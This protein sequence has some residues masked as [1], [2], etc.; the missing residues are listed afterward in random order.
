ML[1]LEMVLEVVLQAAME[2]V[3]EAVMEAE[4]VMAQAPLLRLPEM[5]SSELHG[6]QPTESWQ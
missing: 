6:A 3:M 2:A 1:A 5:V 4:S